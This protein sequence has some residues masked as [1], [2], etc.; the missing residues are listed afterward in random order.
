M[1]GDTQTPRPP[2]LDA[3]ERVVVRHDDGDVELVRQ[4]ACRATRAAASPAGSK[5]L[6]RLQGGSLVVVEDEAPSSGG[7]GDDLPVYRVGRGG[8]LAVA[9]GRIHV[10]LAAGARLAARE[11]DLHAAGYEI[12]HVP[13][14][15]PHSGFVRARE[16]GAG[17]ALAR[18]DAL[19]ALEGIEA[20]EPELLT[21]VAHR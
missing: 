6:F 9:T 10:R 11:V 20:V 5:E 17:S 18:L 2:P 8:P 19:R 1:K 14:Y 12:A 4:P 3:P 7:A 15:A 21:P 16:G 13:S